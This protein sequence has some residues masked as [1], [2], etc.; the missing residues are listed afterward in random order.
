MIRDLL[1]A[2]ANALW[3][4]AALFANGELGIWLDASDYSTLF[5]DSAGS[6]P[7]TANSQPVGLW[8][9]KSGNGNHVT[10]ASSGRRG[11]TNTTSGK[12]YIEFDG[13]FTDSSGN[14]NGL[15]LDD[16]NFIPIVCQLNETISPKHCVFDTKNKQSCNT[17]VTTGND[18]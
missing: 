18:K 10:Q 5:Q 6:T 1:F 3:T 15:L 16:L 9:D 2:S 12:F 11:I 13:G 17:V 4:P 7:V 8:Q 14:K